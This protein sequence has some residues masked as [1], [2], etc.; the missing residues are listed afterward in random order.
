MTTIKKYL[1]YYLVEY[2]R[3]ILFHFRL[4]FGFS[5]FSRKYYNDRRDVFS[6]PILT[7]SRQRVYALGFLIHLIQPISYVYAK[8]SHCLIY[9]KGLD[10]GLHSVSG[11]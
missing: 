4:M 9:E 5:F 1:S 8:L 2:I 7:S 3:V 11:L 10:F 6:L